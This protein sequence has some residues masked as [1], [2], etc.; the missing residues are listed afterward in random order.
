MLSIVLIPTRKTGR[1]QRSPTPGCWSRVIGVFCDKN[2][3]VSRLGPG[4]V[5]PDCD[6][7]NYS[8]GENIEHE[9]LQHIG[10]QVS[11]EWCR[12]AGDGDDWHI[13]GAQGGGGGDVQ[14]GAAGAVNILQTGCLIRFFRINAIGGGTRGSGLRGGPQTGA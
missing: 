11:R 7:I 2:G 8:F 4:S 9:L 13:L 14:V 6:L 1:R 3:R 12:D 5:F 10:A